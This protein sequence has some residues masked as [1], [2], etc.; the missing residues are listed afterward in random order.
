ME[1]NNAET[2]GRP[3][4]FQLNPDGINRNGRPKKEWTWRSLLIEAAEKEELDAVTGE[5]IPVKQIMAKKLVEKGKEGDVQA[6][7]EFADRIDG[8][9]KQPVVGGDEDDPPIKQSIT[10]TFK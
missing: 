4:G 3:T 10:V 6:L 8:K 1:N 5:K 7:K 2:T 9:A